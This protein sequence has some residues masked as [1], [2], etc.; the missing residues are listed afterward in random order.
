VEE[1][2]L[3]RAIAR[4]ENKVLDQF[5]NTIAKPEPVMVFLEFHFVAASE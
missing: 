2:F 3:A 1:E 5:Q 4:G